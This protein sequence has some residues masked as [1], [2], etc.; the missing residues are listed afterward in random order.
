MSLTELENYKKKVVINNRNKWK[1]FK[2]KKI[3]HINLKAKYFNEIKNG[4]KH[5]EYRLKNEYW[6]KRLE[7]RSYDEIHFKL[8]YPKND[9][10]EKIIKTPYVG[11]EIQ[12]LTH[13]LFGVKEVEVYAIIIDK[14]TF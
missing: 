8:G 5:F 3:L 1:D 9:E 12:R 10:M 2:M 13:E 6:V 11:F 14:R 7:N 4:I